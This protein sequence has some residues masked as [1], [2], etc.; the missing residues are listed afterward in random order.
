[1]A[2]L[3]AFGNQYSGA[4][5]RHSPKSRYPP[6]ALYPAP[7]QSRTVRSKNETINAG[8]S[9]DVRNGAV[10][11]DANL[12]IPLDV[13]RQH[14]TQAWQL[15]PRLSQSRI[16]VQPAPALLY[17]ATLTPK[18]AKGG[19]VWLFIFGSNRYF[20]GTSSTYTVSPT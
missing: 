17:Q 13:A 15:A 19:G 5:S 1:M 7:H 9:G 18:A 4:F 10:A 20:S 12:F 3:R 2:I 14:S 11:R 6:L 16:H 8:S